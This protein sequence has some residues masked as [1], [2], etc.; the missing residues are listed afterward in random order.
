M[1]RKLFLLIFV[2]GMSVF[3]A[4]NVFDYWRTKPP[5]CDFSAA[6]GVPLALGRWGGYVGTVSIYWR[7]LLADIFIA[8][9]ASLF[10]A[11]VV[12]KLFR[13]RALVKGQV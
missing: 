1:R 11:F 5:C 8:G 12:E 4:A 9:I 10:L 7:G 13:R 6:F 2:F 3:V